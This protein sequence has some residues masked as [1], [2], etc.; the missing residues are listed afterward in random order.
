VV[1]L[2]AWDAHTAWGNV[3]WH[4]DPSI[5]ATRFLTTRS[6]PVGELLVEG[7]WDEG[8]PALVLSLG[9]YGIG[10]AQ[11]YAISLA[12]YA[13]HGMEQF[14]GMAPP[15]ISDTSSQLPP[16]RM[17]ITL[18]RKGKKFG[19]GWTSC[20]R[21][22]WETECWREVDFLP[23]VNGL[24]VS[25]PFWWNISTWHGID[26]GKQIALRSSPK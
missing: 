20:R 25:C 1:A 2:L 17:N 10:I 26:A 21:F 22:D 7:L 11:Q 8:R 18:Q 16:G 3:A 15:L 5:N 4:P 23:S 6:C 13:F 19:G 9:V 14:C 12:R 24:D